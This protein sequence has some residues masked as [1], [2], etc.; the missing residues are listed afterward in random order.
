MRNMSFFYT[1]DQVRAGTKTETTRPGWNFLK[2]GDRVM[3]CE[4]CQ[5]LGKGGK[6]VKIRPIEIVKTEKI[7]ALSICYTKKNVNAEGFPG[8]TPITFV[9]SILVEKCKLSLGDQVN[10]ITFKYI[11]EQSK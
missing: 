7:H 2:P 3:A 1:K 10:R 4:K 5:G 6:I 8:M 9:R 11:K